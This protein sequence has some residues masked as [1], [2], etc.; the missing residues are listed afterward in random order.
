[1][2]GTFE[3][4][5]DE[6]TR[7]TEW[8]QTAVDTEAVE[9]LGAA[10]VDFQNFHQRCYV[11]DMKHSNL[12]KLAPPRHGNANTTQQGGDPVA[13]IFPQVKA[14]VG[15]PPYAVYRPNSIR[16]SKDVLKR[17][18]S[19]GIQYGFYLFIIIFSLFIYS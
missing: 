17:H 7:F 12:G 5:K 6:T 4:P 2:L 10:A 19:T 16:F 11:P 14:L 8:I 15:Q 3:C 1:M 13:E 9:F 18:L